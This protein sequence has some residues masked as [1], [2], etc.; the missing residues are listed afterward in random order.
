MEMRWGQEG[1]DTLGPGGGEMHDVR[2]GMIEGE[3]VKGR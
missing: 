3:R 2:K 1:K